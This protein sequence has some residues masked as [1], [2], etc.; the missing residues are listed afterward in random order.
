M[1]LDFCIA[2][3]T[4][5]VALGTKRV[6]QGS[7]LLL[8]LE[9]NRRRL[10]KRLAKLV[11]GGDPPEDLHIGIN[12]PRLD[13]AGVQQIEAWLQEHQDARLVVVDT[14]AKVRPRIK[15]QNVYAEDYAA[16]EKLLPLAAE[17]GVAVVV[18]H[19]LRKTGAAD[20]LDEISGS[21]G[22]SGGVDGALILKRDRGRADA[23]LHVTGRDIEEDAEHALR[24]DHTLAA[25]TLVGDANEYRQS[26]ERRAIIELLETT[27]PL[28]PKDV[29]E[30]LDKNANTTRVLLRKMLADGQVVVEEGFEVVLG[31]PRRQVDQKRYSFVAFALIQVLDQRVCGRRLARAGFTDDEQASLGGFESGDDVRGLLGDG[32]RLDEAK[33][34]HPPHARC[35]VEVQLL[36]RGRDQFAARP[37]GTA[38]NLRAQLGVELA[39]SLF[40]RL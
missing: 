9:E 34:S 24:W 13:E 32:L 1:A 6:E 5:G 25:W 18:V 17:H 26:E 16:L 8:A 40:D 15:G 20:P 37:V 3:A 33:V 12:W 19:H 31:L 21:T 14:L 2:V 11:V 36:Q 4:G 27:G 23:Y 22:L 38:L 30:T 28:A 7:S 29:A 39:D 10:Q 35:Y